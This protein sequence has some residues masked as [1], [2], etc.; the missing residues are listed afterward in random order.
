MGIKLI[1]VVLAIKLFSFSFKLPFQCFTLQCRSRN[2]TNCI[3]LLHLFPCYILL[4]EGISGRQEGRRDKGFSP[5]SLL[6]LPVCYSIAARLYTGRNWSGKWFE[7]A[8]FP[9]SQNHL[10]HIPSER[11]ALTNH[12]LPLRD[13]DSS[14]D[15]VLIQALHTQLLFR[16]L[17]PI[18]SFKPLS[19]N[20]SHC[21][22]S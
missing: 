14:F 6:P 19:F 4:I 21:F 11:P 16:G 7:F 20:N 22:P 13:P 1:K 17:D 3:S 18:F 12:F 15:E 5:F 9:H 10:H 8:V 2:P